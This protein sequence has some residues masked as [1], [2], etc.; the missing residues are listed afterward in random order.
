VTP[1]E[2]LMLI[3]GVLHLVA[4][5]LGVVLFV[6]FVRSD[7]GSRPG[8]SDDD[9]SGGG[10]GND[11]ISGHP[12][13]SPPGGIPLPDAVPAPVRL[14]GTERLRDLRGRPGRRRVVEPSRPSR[15]RVR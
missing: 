13:D 12:K 4:L 14:R 5:A 1:D 15:R 8:R 6:M 7:R 11:R 3:F 10:G 9:E 2:E